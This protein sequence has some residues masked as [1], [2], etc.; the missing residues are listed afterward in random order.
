M[1]VTPRRTSSEDEAPASPPRSEKRVAPYEML[2]QA[3]LSGALEPGEPLVETALAAWCGVS[4]TPIR[5]A[6]R[7]LQQ[8]ELIERSSRGFT[9]RTRSPEEI[10]DVYSVR[11]V[12]EATAAGMAAE[13]RDEHDLR[14]LHWALG[15]GAQT[16]ADGV[17]ELVEAN[18]AFHHAVWRA[19][20][21]KPLVDLLERLHLHLGRYPGTTLKV[22]GRWESARDQH[23]ALVDAIERRDAAAAHDIAMRHFQDARD[24]RLSLFAAEQLR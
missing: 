6:L 9:V 7:R 24:I 1:A 8:D 2:K 11:T 20:H 19:S 13:R 5:E 10:L 12:L 18:Q 23:Q 16:A 21:N 4:R 15:K 14:L 3:I 17:D 22:P